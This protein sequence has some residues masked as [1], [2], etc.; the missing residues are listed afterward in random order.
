[1][2]AD[3]TEWRPGSFTKNYSWGQP[4]EGLRRLHEAIKIGFDGK[5][6][7]VLRDVFRRRLKGHGRPDYI[8]LNFFLLNSVRDFESYIIPD[9]L[10]FQA[11]NFEHDSNFDKLAITTFNISY[12]GHWNGARKFQAYPAA[13]AHYFVVEQISRRRGWQTR[14]VSA[15]EI[16]RF[17]RESGKYTGDTSRKLATNL[18]YMYRVGGFADL[19]V[20]RIEH[21][22]VNSVFSA[23][24]R[25]VHERGL[26]AENVPASQLVQFLA[27]SRFS[28]LSGP[29]SSNKEL[30]LLPLA[31]LYAACGGAR[32]HSDEAVRERQQSL[33][34][35]IHWFANS[36]EPFFAIYPNDPNIIKSLPRVCAMLA[37]NLAGFEELDPDELTNWNVLEYVRKKTRVALDKLRTESITPTMSAEELMKITRGE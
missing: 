5:L 19:S 14:V 2:L 29:R 28:D 7:P 15:D 12:V 3:V 31:T 8:P 33:L 20:N 1:M 30:A 26:E 9:E 34:P 36:Q 22:W 32:R 25:A 24:D 10:V 23:L 17:L 37:K 35:H 27:R 11:L 6:E 4:S 21:W 16:E 18:S 13:W